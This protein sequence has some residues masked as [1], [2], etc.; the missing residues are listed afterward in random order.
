MHAMQLEKIISHKPAAYVLGVPTL[1][2]RLPKELRT[3]LARMLMENDQQVSRYCWER[4]A[5][6][7]FKNVGIENFTGGYYFCFAPESNRYCEIGEAEA[8]IWDQTDGAC[9]ARLDQRTE[10]NSNTATHRVQRTPIIDAKG[11][12]IVTF[13]PNCAK[14]WRVIDG[15]CIALASGH[16]GEVRSLAFNSQGTVLASGSED[17]TVKLWDPNTGSLSQTF[18]GHSAPVRSVRFND[19][20]S[21]LVSVSDDGTARI[22]NVKNGTC[23][24]I[25]SDSDGQPLSLGKFNAQSTNIVTATRNKRTVKVWDITNGQCIKTLNLQKDLREDCVSFTAT[26]NQ[27]ILNVSF[28]RAIANIFDGSDGF[29]IELPESQCLEL[30]PDGTL[31]AVSYCDNSIKIFRA[32]DLSLI[33]TLRGQA[34]NFTQ[35][36]WNA[37][38]DRLITCSAS[39]D[40]TI[41][42]WDVATGSCKG[43]IGSLTESR[44]QVVISIE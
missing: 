23:Q 30:S 17:T 34:G 25:L 3:I 9:I 15:A 2:D 31:M 39:N 20:G 18:E 19:L 16:T 44:N 40:R 4:G 10:Y 37:E 8:Y 14:I 26:G 28:F 32:A 6:V 21:L 33:S 29:L 27:L 12:K 13:G 22:W 24:L 36:F 38:Q 11:T 1:F 35:I 41:R 5:I 7:N 43:I 42:I